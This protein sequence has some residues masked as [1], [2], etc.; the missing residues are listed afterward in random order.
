MSFEQPLTPKERPGCLPA[1]PDLELQ[2]EARIKLAA[3]QQQPHGDKAA[4]ILDGFLDHLPNEG[5]QNIIPFIANCDDDEFLLTLSNHL[6]SAIL[7]PLRA[8]SAPEVTPSPPPDA[9][10]G[11]EDIAADMIE[12]SSRS[13]QSS[14][15]RQCFKR[16]NYR[17]M[18][19]GK[20]DK[21]YAPGNIANEIVTQTGK[22]ELVHIL[23]FSLGKYRNSREEI[24]LIKIWE[25]IYTCFPAIRHHTNLSAS[26]IN[27]ISNLMSLL[28]E[29]HDAFGEFEVALESTSE[30]NSYRLMI[31]RSFP[32]YM[33]HYL[34]PLLNENNECI[35][36]FK[37]FADFE[38]PSQ[39]LLNTHAAIAK[40]LHATGIAEII[41]NIFRD[42]RNYVALLQMEV[43]T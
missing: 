19:T 2:R 13:S 7:I 35:I 16:D 9:E 12:P 17:C 41:E 38:L 10:H 27:D 5:K 15:K 1:P 42:K 33:F 21:K 37:Q 14:L 11:Y 18:I 24:R 30:E 22:T 31:Y 25:A 43:R 39:V 8:R 28:G 23:P 3:Y 36:T 40:I 26:K 6:Q 34:P 4:K 20:Y 29:L 32:T